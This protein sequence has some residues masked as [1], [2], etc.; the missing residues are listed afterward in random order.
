MELTPAQA[1][2]LLKDAAAKKFAET[3]E[4]FAGYISEEAIALAANEERSVVTREDVIE[5]ES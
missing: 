4:T 1:K 2:E 5:A 3:L